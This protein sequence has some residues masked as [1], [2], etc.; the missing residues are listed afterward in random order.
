MVSTY[1]SYDL[2]NRDMFKTLQRVASQDMVARDAAYYAENIGK[3]TSIDEFLDDYRLFSY[4]MKAHGLEEMTYAK[5]FMKKVLE[6]DLSDANSYANLLTDDRYKEF[7]SRLQFLLKRH[8]DRAVGRA[9][10]GDSRPL[11]PE[12]HRYPG[13]GGGG[14]A[15]LQGYDGAGRSCGRHPEQ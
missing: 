10:G 6:S 4:A 12:H 7:R 5:A 3:V 8:G 13:Q 2:V 15:L 9:A 14:D 1:L 11:R